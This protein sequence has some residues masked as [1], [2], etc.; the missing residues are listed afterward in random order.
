MPVQTLQCSLFGLRCVRRLC[1]SLRYRLAHQVLKHCV[2][3]CVS[4]RSRACVHETLCPANPLCLFWS[5]RSPSSALPHL[6]HHFVISGC[7]LW[8]YVSRSSPSHLVHSGSILTTLFVHTV[9][10]WS[11]IAQ[12]NCIYCFLFPHTHP[13][14]WVLLSSLPFSSPLTLLCMCSRCLSI[15]LSLPCTLICC[16]CVITA[17]NMLQD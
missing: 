8:F 13:R 4:V 9:L 14:L 2:C 5:A 10:I 6:W 11:H 17:V 12:C 16:S 7:N 3:V 15:S 1:T